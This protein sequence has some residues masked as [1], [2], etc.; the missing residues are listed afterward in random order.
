MQGDFTSK[1]TKKINTYYGN[2]LNT[3]LCID[4]KWSNKFSV[5]T[6]INEIMIG[7]QKVKIYVKRNNTD[8]IIKTETADTETADTETADSTAD[9]TADTKTE[10]VDSDSDSDSDSDYTYTYTDGKIEKLPQTGDFTDYTYL[11]GGVAFLVLGIGVFITFKK[12]I[13]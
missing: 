9:S 1:I 8:E 4:G 7:K 5:K 13:Q 12:K 6:G 11:M 3:K 10:I 2:S